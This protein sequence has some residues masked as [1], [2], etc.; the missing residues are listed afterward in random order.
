M[1]TY[2]SENLPRDVNFDSGFLS[3]PEDAVFTP[4]SRQMVATGIE[5]ATLFRSSISGDQGRWEIY[6]PSADGSVGY[7]L[8]DPPDGMDDLAAG[9]VVTMDPIALC[10]WTFEQLVTFNG[11]D[12]DSINEWMAA[13][14]RYEL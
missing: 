11:E 1:V 3:F 13:C 5:G 10:C 14:T 7:T 8:P 2:T 12:L 9:T 4:A 6:L